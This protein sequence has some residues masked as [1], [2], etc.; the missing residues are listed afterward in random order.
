MGCLEQAEALSGSY[1]RYCIL[2]MSANFYSTFKSQVLRRQFVRAA[3]ALRESVFKNEMERI[4]EMKIEA[5]KWIE[6]VPKKNWASVYFPGSRYNELPTNAVE[7]FNVIL[8][9]AREL[10][11]TSLVDHIRWKDSNFFQSHHKLGHSW[12]THLTGKA[13]EWFVSPC[14]SACRY[15]PYACSWTE[16]EV[17]SLTNADRVDLEKKTCTCGRFQTIGLP[18]EHVITAMGMN[19]LDP[20]VYCEEWFLADTY[21]NTYDGVVYPTLDRSQWLEPPNR[22]TLVFPPLVKRQPGR[23]RKCR[24]SK[25]LQIGS[26]HNCGTCGEPGHNKRSCKNR[27]R[28]NRGVNVTPI[29]PSEPIQNRSGVSCQTPFF[30]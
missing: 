22:L 26:H 8:K 29:M 21:L 9:E 17:K 13:E 12:N 25:G 2:H 5:Y 11:I 6:E 3:Y 28:V 7:C 19:H 23:P 4:K 1:H 20:Y 15:T 16:F 27:P 30:V 10:P 18:C 14:D 24:L